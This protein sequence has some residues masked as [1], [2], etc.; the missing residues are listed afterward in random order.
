MKT[1]TTRFLSIAVLIAA[2]GLSMTGCAKS[3]LEA[4][5]LAPPAYS[6]S[7]NFSRQMRYAAFD[8]QQVIDD[9]DRHVTM[10]RPGSTLTKWHVYQ[11][12]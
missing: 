1:S 12:D 4:D 8:Q 9:F 10:S 5:L 2:G 6:S 7:E 3:G 11:S